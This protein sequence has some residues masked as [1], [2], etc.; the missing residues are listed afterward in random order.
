MQLFNVSLT[1]SLLGPF[2]SLAPCLS[3]SFSL[4]LSEFLSLCLSL[5]LSQFVYVFITL[6]LS[7]SLLLSLSLS[8]SLPLCLALSLSVCLKSCLSILS[9]SSLFRLLSLS[10]YI[11]HVQYKLFSPGVRL[12]WFRRGYGPALRVPCEQSSSFRYAPPDLQV[13]RM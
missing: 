2:L 1:F 8:L 11:C 10:I 7:L 9:F 4:C 13:L 5:S 3:H 6:Y 12:P